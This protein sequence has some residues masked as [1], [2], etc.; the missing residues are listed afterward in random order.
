VR[1]AV[2][3]A[4][5]RQA[6]NLPWLV[7]TL[8]T[9]FQSLR[10]R[11]RSRRGGGGDDEKDL[12]VI[13]AA[14]AVGE[15]AGTG[16]GS[17]AE[18]RARVRIHTL[19]RQLDSVSRILHT[20][21]TVVAE[22]GIQLRQAMAQSRGECAGFDLLLT[23]G[24]LREWEDAP[25]GSG[26]ARH[27]FHAHTPLTPEKPSSAAER[28]TAATATAKEVTVVASAHGEGRPRGRR[29]SRTVSAENL[30]PP[31]KHGLNTAEAQLRRVFC[32]AAKV[33][34]RSESLERAIERARGLLEQPEHA[35]GGAAHRAYSLLLALLLEK[36]G[37][38]AEALR[39]HNGAGALHRARVTGLYVRLFAQLRVGPRGA[40]ADPSV[41]TLDDVADID[42]LI[43]LE[44]LRLFTVGSHTWL[45][46]RV[47]LA[48]ME[49]QEGLPPDS[50][51]RSHSEL[52]RTPRPLD[53]EDD[54]AHAAAHPTSPRHMGVLH[55]QA[56]L[57]PRG[58]APSGDRG[59]ARVLNGR[60]VLARESVVGLG[61]AGD[62][63]R[64][65]VEV[66]KTQA[67]STA[68]AP[69]FV[70]LDAA[71]LDSIRCLSAYR[72]WADRAAKLQVCVC[73][74]G[75]CA[76]VRLWALRACHVHLET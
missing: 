71:A 43:G 22:A 48:I 31:A 49:L 5:G 57:T 20:M 66:A 14:E 2:G 61:A 4:L 56:H 76:S 41:F 10:G 28:P 27:F 53:A 74:V 54:I 39:A 19:T 69:R 25:S 72:R 29:R 75:L 40:D 60:R 23:P 17:A 12:V 45:R 50:H 35:A 32:L 64:E 7:Q 30:P 55:A 47:G 9:Q 24:G 62:L 65:L 52:P 13:S 6:V 34:G 3:E 21:D 26:T 67:T 59:D 51:L 16:D 38:Y 37:S 33:Y 15:G 58:F 36:A 18:E 42:Q 11:I 70:G 8:L 46:R 63:L 68:R 44:G 73:G 1:A